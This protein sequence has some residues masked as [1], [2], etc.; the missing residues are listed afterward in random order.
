MSAPSDP[1][2]RLSPGPA[3]A[4]VGP[5]VLAL[6][7][8]GVYHIDMCGGGWLEKVNPLPRARRSAKS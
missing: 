3:S 1:R 4:G 8:F 5:Y 6:A 2:N 7:V